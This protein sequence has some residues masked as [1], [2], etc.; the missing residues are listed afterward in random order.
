MNIRKST[1]WRVPLYCIIAGKISF[2]LIIYFVSK[3]A[4][5]KTPTDT[6]TI[7]VTIDDAKV[8]LFYGIIFV[9]SILA[10]RFF[11]HTMTRKEIFLSSTIIVVFYM[12]ITVIQFIMGNI[13]GSFAI[14]FMYLSQTFEWSTFISQLFLKI[15][16]MQF[17]WIATFFQNLMPY[18][19]VF[20]GKKE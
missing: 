15:G 10:G 6:G 17:Q 7:T 14:L 2:Y 1:L 9:V 11:F 3:F 12:I 20:F 4:V 16:G 8:L 19:F 18:L 5:I 13:T